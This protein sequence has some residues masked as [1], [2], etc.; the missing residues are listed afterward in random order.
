[1]FNAALV[2]EQLAKGIQPVKTGYF[3]YDYDGMVIKNITWVDAS[4]GYIKIYKEP[5]KGVPY[6]IG[7]DTAGE[8]SD[9]FAA[10]VIDNTDGLQA[11]VL[12]HRFDEDL[13][14]RQ[15]F[16]LGKYYNNALISVE[17]NF[18]T[19]PVRE[20]D[21]MGYTSLYVRRTEDSYTQK[22]QKSYGFKTTSVTRPVAIARLVEVMRLSPGLVCDSDTLEEMLTFVRNENGRPEAQQGSHDDLVMALAIAHYS[23]EQQRGDIILPSAAVWSD[24]MYD[25][26]YKADE[27]TRKIILK[28]WGNPFEKQ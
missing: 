3:A 5:E 27:E 10:H 14:A 1:V 11:A 21:R 13:Y 6:V 20:L 24:D 19:Y 15:M 2:S 28:K 23:R 25:D 26:Y 4:D 18:S 9:Y 17:V 7:G 12:H 22:L 8:G 16:C